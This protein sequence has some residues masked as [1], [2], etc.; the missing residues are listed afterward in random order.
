MESSW[1][2]VAEKGAV[3]IYETRGWSQVEKFD[4][5]IGRL[6]TLRWSPDGKLLAVSGGNGFCEVLRTP[7]FGSVV[8]LKAHSGPCRT[9]EFSADGRVLATGGDDG[10]VRLW[11]T[12]V[13][14]PQREI[15]IGRDDIFCL[16][17]HPEGLILAAGDR[18]GRVTLVGVPEARTLAGFESGGPVMTIEF[19]GSSLIVGSLDRPI[20]VWDFGVLARCVKG[21]RDFWKWRLEGGKQDR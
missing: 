14:K 6:A 19:V 4:L 13:W 1:R 20:G 11:D 2:S 18:A 8:R 7:D 12:K 17:F 10:V 3:A 15:P 16:A 9:A 21:N 5:K